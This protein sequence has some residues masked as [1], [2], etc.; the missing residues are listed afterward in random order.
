VGAFLRKSAVVKR[1]AEISSRLG[2]ATIDPTIWPELLD[3]I[4]K[5]VGAAG[6]GLLQSDIRTS[7]MPRSAGADE[8]ISS[9]FTNG[10]HTRDVR[11]ERGAPL[12]VRGEKV[13]T[14]QD[15]V[16][17][18]EMRTLGF[19]TENL[20]PFGFRWF[21]AIGFCSGSALWAVCIQRTM[22]EGPFDF[23]DKCVLGQLSEK[24]TETAT[25][26]RAVGR[27]VLSG[28]TNALHLVKQPAL[29][30]DRQGFVIDTNAA[31]EELFDEEIRVRGRRLYVRDQGARFQLDTLVDQLRIT[32]DT[33]VLPAS[34]IVV[35][36]LGGRPVVI[37]I[38]PIGGAA[39]SP[40][41][42]A[43]ALLIFSDLARK[44]GPLPELLS[45]AFGLS[46]AEARL[47]SLIAT[48]ISPE[49]A[50]EQ[51]GVARET[52]RNQLKAVFA[53]TNTHRQGELIALLSRL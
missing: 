32:P 37:R 46:P 11:A 6:A 49:R 28:I 43:R 40:F 51:L 22:R 25:L 24:L 17:P 7:D 48:G 4:S 33:V 26:S 20:A 15:I 41:F 13:V 47:A 2:D 23:E 52:A 16:T 38:V 8:V 10:W 39:R 45:R 31:A 53:K 35:Q 29:A 1:L 27:A 3:Q 18:E 5:A 36:R 50:A 42:G 19:Y 12:L 14:D 44:S 34:P 30:L 21:A 9:Y